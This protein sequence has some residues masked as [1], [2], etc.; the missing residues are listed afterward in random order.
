MSKI[1][2]SVGEK[3]RTLRKKS[4]LSQ[5]RLAFKAG[6]APSYMGQVERGTKSPTIDILEKIAVALDVT[7]EELFSF[8]QNVSEQVDKTIIEKI[9]FQLYGRSKMEQEAI[10]NFV[11]QLLLFRDKK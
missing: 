7:L 6:I 10:Y 2:L 8:D 3:I 5:E 11:K 9:A 1:A 4:G